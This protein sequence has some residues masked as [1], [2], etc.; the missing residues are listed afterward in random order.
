MRETLQSLLHNPIF[1]IVALIIA[2]ILLLIVVLLLVRSQRG[3]GKRED[4]LRAELVEMERE[5]QFAAAA[6]QMPFTR[7]AAAAALEASQVFRE[8]LGLPLLAVY[9]GRE[10]DERLTNILPK[11]TGDQPTG[12]LK[13]QA[14]ETLSAPVLGN[15]WKPQHTKLGFFTGELPAAAFVTGSLV[16]DQPAADEAIEGDEAA[17]QAPRPPAPASAMAGLDVIVFPWRAAY[18]WTGMFLAQA[19]QS[20][21]PEA[22]QRLREPVA[23]LADRLA[24]ALEF[25]RERQELF[26]LDERA[27]RSAAFSRAVIACLDEPSPLAAI[28]GEV[29]RLLGTESAALWRIEAGAGMVRMVAAH[30][31]KS[32]EFLPLPIGQGLAGSIAQ[33]GEPLALENAPADPHCIFPREARE[34]GIVAY[35]GV[36]V[37][38]DEQ[39]LG[40][41][42]VHAPQPRRWS[43]SDLRTLSSAASVI[44]E[45]LKSTDQRGNRLRVESA[46]LGLSEALQRLRTPEEV[47]EA[48][49]EV[50][51]HALGV[52]RALIVPLNDKGDAR[53]VQHEFV[54]YGSKPAAGASFASSELTRLAALA[55]GEPLTIS[56]SQ[57]ASPM[58]IDNVKELQVLS[59]MI[60]PVRIEGAT[61]ALLYLHQCDR[62][63]EWQRDEVEFADRVV[64]QLAL[65]LSNVQSFDKAVREAQSAREEALRTGGQA[66]GRIRELEQKLA[67]AERA[68]NEGRAADQQARA[69]WAKASAAEA[70]ARAEAEVVRHAEADARQERDR[71]RSEVARLEASNQQL[72]EIN[73]LKAEFIVN[74]GREIDGS[75]QSV[76]GIV[77]LIERGN[78]GP[79]SAE[80]HEA[81]RAA[82][83]SARRMKNDV[84]WLIEYG[85]ARARRL[86]EGA[87]K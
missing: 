63:R 38:S 48:V 36:A 59:E 24:V 54:A 18:D 72:L 2:F 44:A 5:H 9:A 85:S 80:Q 79:L 43:E 47:M 62:K 87:E 61:R 13:A 27:S 21:T 56:D 76:L 51:G 86:E 20:H 11:A 19:A 29:A 84:D 16:K 60:V 50:L 10:K 31:L 7:D 78:F 26:A 33:T 52:S 69:L 70:K 53:P 34:S 65:S 12:G 4:H 49:V 42:E 73:R 66:A 71:L 64:R 74:A 6:E 68:I 83:A 75:L 25:E 37:T 57:Q 67:E 17:A 1:L 3:K 81:V 46:Y 15:F 55:D 77:E 45:I 23:R 82:Y 39:A 28:A 22:L 40:I 41:V 58:G 8:Y 14:P 32:A 35:L 30:G